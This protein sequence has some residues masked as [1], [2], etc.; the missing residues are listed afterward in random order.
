MSAA[1]IDL[2][3]S[4]IEKVLSGISIPPQPKI[5]QELQA[6]RKR[7]FPNLTNVAN[8]ISKDVGLSAAVLKTINSPF[9]GLAQKVNSIQ[10]A[11]MLLGADKILIIVTASVLRETIRGKASINLDRF[12][13]RATD[14]ANICMSIA[15]HCRLDNID[16]VYALGL[17]HDSG[18]AMLAR[19]Y[20]NYKEVQTESNATQERSLAQVED[21]YFNTNHA[22]IG[23]YLSKSWFLPDEIVE[24]IRDHHD[25]KQLFQNDEKYHRRND[26]MAVLRMASNIFHAYDRVSAE[27][28]WAQIRDE[29][30]DQLGLSESEYA[31]IEL[32]IHDALSKNR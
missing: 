32:D 29:V 7:G 27:P 4:H 16:D 14:V 19:K 13:N 10:Q 25:L 8:L 20:D 6:E 30:F 1:Q 18:V 9:Y 31:D 11:V 2:D 5:L 3:K 12:W 26:L 17:F 21:E 24:V 22:T 15:R 28:E 23:F